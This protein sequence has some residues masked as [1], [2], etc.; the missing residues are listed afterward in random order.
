MAKK[1]KVT[2]WATKVK[3]VPV[4]VSFRRWDGTRVSF[5]ATKAVR[6]PKKVSFYSRRK[7]RWY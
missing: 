3:K 2:F 6:V 1:K 7:R 5:K 4:K